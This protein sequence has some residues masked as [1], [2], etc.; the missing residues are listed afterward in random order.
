MVPELSNYLHVSISSSTET[1]SSERT[2]KLPC[3]FNVGNMSGI[4]G[5]ETF[6]FWD[7]VQQ[8]DQTGLKLVW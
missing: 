1:E 3:G 6:S 2:D 5:K 4:E 8:L 7:C